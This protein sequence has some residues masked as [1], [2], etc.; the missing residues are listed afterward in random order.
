VGERHSGEGVAR[1]EGLDAGRD[2]ADLF[3]LPPMAKRLNY[4]GIGPRTRRVMDF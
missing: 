1:T 4:I 2:S 3:V